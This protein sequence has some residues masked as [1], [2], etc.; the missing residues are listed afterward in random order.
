LL[1]HILGP[2]FDELGWAY[3]VALCSFRSLEL[4]NLW[5]TPSVSVVFNCGL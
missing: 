3:L 5:R 2:R 1:I 4:D